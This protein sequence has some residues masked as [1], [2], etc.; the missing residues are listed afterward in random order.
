MSDDT[1]PFTVKD[2]RQFTSD[3]EV[4]PETTPA[5]VPEATEPETTPVSEG[6]EAE[7]Q[8]PSDFSG[9][10][11]SL[12]TQ[13]AALLGLEPARLGAARSLITLLEVLKDK[14]GGH[15]TKEEEQLLDGLLYELRMVYVT[16]SRGGA[17]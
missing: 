9:L 12:G 14:T 16:K 1:K 15:R 2:R 3:G 11:L 8:F 7:P 17:A 6:E 5:P 4:R 13:A 10:L